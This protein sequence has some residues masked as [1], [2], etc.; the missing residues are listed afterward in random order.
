MN[1]TYT[2]IILYNK[3][4]FFIRDYRLIVPKIQIRL[5]KSNFCVTRNEN[6]NI[7]L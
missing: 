6:H 1:K 5:V 4:N 7:F 3:Y 2:L